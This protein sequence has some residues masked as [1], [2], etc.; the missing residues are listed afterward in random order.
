MIHNGLKRT[1]SVS[2]RLE[3]LQVYEHARDYVVDGFYTIRCMIEKY[4]EFVQLL[5]RARDLWLIVSNSYH[6]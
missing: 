2:G 1:I 3:P 5:E 4:F 6:Y